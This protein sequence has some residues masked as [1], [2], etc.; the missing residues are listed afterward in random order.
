MLNAAKNLASDFNSAAANLNT[1]TSGLNQT[2]TQT[3]SQINTLTQ[4]IAQLNG[5]VATLKKEGQ[6]PGTVEDQENQLINQLSQ[7][8]NVSE[9][10][11]PD[12]L[13]LTTGN[14]APVG[15]CQPELRAPDLAQFRQCERHFAGP[16]HHEHDQRRNFG[17]NNSSP[18]HGHSGTS[19]SARIILPAS[20]L[21]ALIPRKAP[22]TI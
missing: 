22:A 2:V 16:G 14:G 18:R 10:Q 8:T 17:R 7:L 20:L 19:Y 11:T 9:T 3:V 6:D 15:G 4:Q 1:I 13:T 5:Q 12:G 21:P